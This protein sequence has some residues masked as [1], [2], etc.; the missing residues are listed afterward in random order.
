[1]NILEEFNNH[2]TYR[3]RQA[4]TRERKNSGYDSREI[5]EIKARV[6]HIIEETMPELAPFEK[7]DIADFFLNPELPDTSKKTI[8]NKIESDIL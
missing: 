8:Q 5:Y 6:F 2:L 4:I 7:D 1:M 3:N